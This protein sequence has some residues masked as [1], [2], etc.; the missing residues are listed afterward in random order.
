MK[1]SLNAEESSLDNNHSHFLLVDDGTEGKY[2]GEID[3]RASFQK[4][5]AK[6]KICDI[7]QI[8]GFVLIL[9]IF[10]NRFALI[11]I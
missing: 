11:K 4:V 1:H 3:F 6:R 7:V 5:L 2:G 10:L 8:E 9:F